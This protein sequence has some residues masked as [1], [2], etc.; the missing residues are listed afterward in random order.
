MLYILDYICA[1]YHIP[2]LEIVHRC[3]STIFY[4]PGS[5]H[6]LAP[7]INLLQ[8]DDVLMAFDGEPIA[9]DG[10]GC[11]SLPLMC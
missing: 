6:P 4:S 1:I 3:L 5:I 9:N 7:C 11:C 10:T 8:K 2:Y